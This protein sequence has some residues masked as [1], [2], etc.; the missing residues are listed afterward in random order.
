MLGNDPAFSTDIIVGFPGETDAEFEET[1]ETCR[2]ARFMK[3]HVFPF[4]RRDGTPAATMPDQV[5][6]D[7][8]RE[9]VRILSDL[10]RELAERFYRSHLNAV[11]PNDDSNLLHVLVERECETR[12]GYVRGSDQWYMPVEVPGTAADLAQFVTCRA[13]SANRNGVVAER[14]SGE[15]P[16]TGAPALTMSSKILHRQSTGGLTPLRSPESCEEFPF[17]LRRCLQWQSAW[18]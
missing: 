4:S 3:V 18:P 2:K 1:L 8:I 12:P 16:I 14:M 15:R 6:P 13:V 10:E 5:P 7:V 9:R 17:L 11:I